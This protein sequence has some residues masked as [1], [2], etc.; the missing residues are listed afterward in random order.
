MFPLVFYLCC[1]LVPRCLLL[2]A[3]ALILYDDDITRRGACRCRW[4]AGKQRFFDFLSPA[5]LPR[6]HVHGARRASA[7]HQHPQPSHT[8]EVHQAARLLSVTGKDSSE[9]T[10]VGKHLVPLTVRSYK[11]KQF[12]YLLCYAALSIFECSRMCFHALP[13]FVQ[14]CERLDGD[15]CHRD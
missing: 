10:F 11:R 9:R 2:L 3:A 6:R 5:V 15:S 1:S 12:C 14:Y 4:Y 8:G 7:F 13:A